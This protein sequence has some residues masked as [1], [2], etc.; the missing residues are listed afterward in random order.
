MAELLA[1]LAGSGSVNGTQPRHHGASLPLRII[2]WPVA[3]PAWA[4]AAGSRRTLTMLAMVGIGFG[5]LAGWRYGFQ[6]IDLG[7]ERMTGSHR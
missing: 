6:K 3:E 1:A 2:G 5:V 7:S 4:R